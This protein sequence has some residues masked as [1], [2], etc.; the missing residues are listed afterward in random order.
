MKIEKLNEHQISCIITTQDLINNQIK[1]SELALGS[2]KAK[3]FFRDIMLKA[4]DDYGFDG[5]NSPLMIEA[6]PQPP[7]MLKLIITKMRPEARG[8]NG[9]AELSEDAPKKIELHFKGADSVLSLFKKAENEK[10]P[11]QNKL[12]RGENS[13]SY[14]Y[15]AIL[16]ALA[17]SSADCEPQ[18]VIEAF[19]FASIDNIIVAA[20]AMKNFYDGENSLYRETGQST[21]LLVV[22]CV[23]ETPEEF[24]KI[25]NMLTEYSIP[26]HCTASGESYLREH[27]NEMIAGNALQVLAK[28]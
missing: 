18:T 17:E 7:D 21:Y 5:L 28:F 3:S 16:K 11:E 4:R 20:K 26:V 19:R 6:M 8:L 2:A 10:A 1:L 13:A 14:V 12:K 23:T 15:D 9:T 22:R 27:D 25:C 24:N